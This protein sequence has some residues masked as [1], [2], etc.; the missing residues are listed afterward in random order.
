MCWS[1]ELCE[2]CNALLTW[3]E[4]VTN[5]T[6]K[7]L[8]SVNIPILM[9]AFITPLIKPIGLGLVWL[10]PFMY[11]MSFSLLPCQIFPRYSYRDH[12]LCVFALNHDKLLSY[13]MSACGFVSWESVMLLMARIYVCTDHCSSSGATSSGMFCLQH[14]FTGKSWS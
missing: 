5:L 8:K 3:Q 7:W 12:I 1:N 6:L 13:I 14:S 9:R 11:L 10:W 2:M 4:S